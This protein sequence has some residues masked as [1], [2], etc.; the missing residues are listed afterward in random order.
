MQYALVW[1]DGNLKDEVAEL[2]KKAQAGELEA[3]VYRPK[4][5]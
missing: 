4:A 3:K 1:G 5:E 2:A